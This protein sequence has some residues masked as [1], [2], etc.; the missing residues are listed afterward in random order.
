MTS[1]TSNEPVSKK[2]KLTPTSI[3]V[4]YWNMAFWRADALRAAL[5]LQGIPFDNVT[6][7]TEMDELKAQKKVPFGA[8]PVM[9]IDGKILSQTQA[10]ATF[11]GK[12]G[13][14][15]P[16]NDDPFAQANCDEI[17]N[18]CTDVTDTVSS[19]FRAEDKKSAREK[20]MDPKDGRL[21]MH[22]NGLNS[23][24]CKDGSEFACGKDSELTVADL[25]VWR[26]YNWFYNGTIDHIP[27]DWIGTSFPNLK[28]IYD[29]V[30]SNEK[31][32]AFKK[33]YYPD[34]K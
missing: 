7:K 13:D 19:T 5:Y 4:Y 28:T 21:Y 34:K 27:I 6:D 16:S 31:I 26:L 18:G 12:L 33:E 24:V 17:I 11:V 32:Q 20:L 15:Y 25:C 10:C 2:P 29:N 8:F 30:E 22:L 14:M 3:K 23:V 9:E 1:S